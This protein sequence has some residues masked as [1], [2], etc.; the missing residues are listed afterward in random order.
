MRGLV[1]AFVFLIVLAFAFVFGLL[2]QQPGFTMAAF[3]ASPIVLIALGWGL[4]AALSGKRFA[5]VEAGA[6]VRAA[7]SGTQLEKAREAAARIRQEG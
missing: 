7:R 4:H 5:L 2:N 3:C 1:I 6:P